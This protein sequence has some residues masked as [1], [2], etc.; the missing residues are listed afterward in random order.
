MF[1]DGQRLAEPVRI[2]VKDG[3]WAPS[4]PLSGAAQCGHVGF[5]RQLL[6]KGIDVNERDKVY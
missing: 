1:V 6:D 2:S 5:V 3:L 4:T